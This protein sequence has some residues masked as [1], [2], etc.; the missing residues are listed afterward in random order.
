MSQQTRNASSPTLEGDAGLSR[1][2]PTQLEAGRPCW[3]RPGVMVHDPLVGVDNLL[4]EFAAELR[5]RGFSVRGFA[6][7]HAAVASGNVPLSIDLSSGAKFVEAQGAAVIHLQRAIEENADLFA[8]GRFPACLDATREVGLPIGSGRAKGL[9]VLTTIAGESIHHWH[10]F[11]RRDGSM[12]A[13]DRRSLWRWWGQDQLY[14]DLVLGVAEDEVVRIACGPRWI[15]VE[16]RFGAGLAY[17]PRHPRELAPTLPK[18]RRE[19]L[20]TLA[21]WS[22]S[23]NPL[24][25][26][27]GVAAINAHYNRFDLE[28]GRGNGVRRFRKAPSPVVVVGAFP[29]VDS[30]LPECLIIEKEPRPGEY[31]TV[32]METLLPGCGGAIVNSSALVNQSLLRILRLV[33]HQ[34]VALI[35]PSTPMTSRLHDYG[36][37]VLG[38]FVVRD[39]DG[40][41]KAIEAGALPKD[42]GRFGRYVHLAEDIASAA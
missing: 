18:L 33:D 8:V 37:A 12:V 32:A 19:S 39:A 30:I 35:G 9:P 14:R 29:G 22:L 24:E 31:P 7:D 1:L 34:T 23:W 5:Q 17:L 28:G 26:A 4:I 41:A 25:A 20:R 3:L 10:S 11:V 38:G 6:R 21:R 42:F 40:L 2:P 27:L 13:P 15:M 16:G 36:L